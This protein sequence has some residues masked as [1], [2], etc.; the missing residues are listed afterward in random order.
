METK[1]LI[2]LLGKSRLE[3]KLGSLESGG[4]DLDNL[5]I[6]ELEVLL[7]LVG[8]A[9]FS[10]GGFVVLGNEGS[11]LLNGSNDL[12]PGTS[13]T[14]R[15]DTIEGQK[16]FHILGNGSTSN[17]VLSDGVGD[18]ETFENGNSVGNTISRIADNTGSTAIG[19][20]GHDGLDSNVK[21]IAVELFE[22]DFGHLL[23]VGLGVSRSLSKEDVVFRGVAS[24][25]IVESVLP[26][27]VHVVPVSNDTGFDGV[28]KL[29]DT[30]H[31]LGFI[32]NVL[33]FLFNTDHSF[34][35]RD[36]NDR[37]EFDGGLSLFRETGLEYTGS[38]INN[39][40]F[41]CHVVFVDGVF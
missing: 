41:V 28:V 19:V 10:K 22:H 15:G 23:S 7:M 33:G 39:D 18:G 26:D 37:G 24:E 40:I 38:I 1:S 9:S 34:T 13:A 20:K 16:F 4:V 21:T 5:S 17:E 8:A 11:L 27:L 3:D 31:L 25:L 12:L 36:T 30:S 14:L 32:T 6:G 2:T 35:S 29:E